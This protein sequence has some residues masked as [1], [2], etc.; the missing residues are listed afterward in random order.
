M[1]EFKVRLSCGC[2]YVDLMF[3]NDTTAQE[4]LEK[5]GLGSSKTVIDDTGK[6]QEGVDTFYGFIIGDDKERP[7]AALFNSIFG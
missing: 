7:L 4:A 2:C 5:A 3:N 6:I 1:K